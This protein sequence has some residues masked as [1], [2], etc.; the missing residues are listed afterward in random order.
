MSREFGPQKKVVPFNYAGEMKYRKALMDLQDEADPSRG[1]KSWVDFQNERNIRAWR[2][3][4]DQY[5][6][7][8]A[9]SS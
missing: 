8:K 9:L 2:R 7:N 1:I 4:Y 3:R 6:L 5:L